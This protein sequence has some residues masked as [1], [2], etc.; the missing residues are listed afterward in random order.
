M[1]ARIARAR[2]ARIA[3]SIWKEKSCLPILFRASGSHCSEDSMPAPRAR[4][5]GPGGLMLP[6]AGETLRPGPCRHGLSLGDIRSGSGIIHH[7]VRQRAVILAARH[8]VA[9]FVSDEKK[10]ECR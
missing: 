4:T 7:I 10:K 2:G 1:I 8:Q 3:K 5:N 9:D 6:E